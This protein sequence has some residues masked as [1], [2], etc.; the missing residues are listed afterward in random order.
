[1]ADAKSDASEQTDT[2]SADASDEISSDNATTDDVVTEDVRSQDPAPEDVEPYVEEPHVEDARSDV[3]EPAQEYDEHDERHASLSSRVLTW[4]VVLF[5]GAGIALWGGPKLAPQ[6]P[7]WAAPAAKFM[8]PGGDAAVRDVAA[9][10]SEVTQQLENVPQGPTPEELT[11]LVQAELSTVQTQ[12]DEKLA[13][14][15]A[16]IAAA[17]TSQMDARISTIETQV[18]GLTAE[19]NALTT[20]VQTALSE[21]GSVSEEALAEITSKSAEVE[22]VKAQ[23]GEITGQVGALT[24]RIED[25]EKAATERLEAA[26]AEAAQAQERAT[27]MAA[28]TAFLAAFD[29]LTAKASEG[30][31]YA[32]ELNTL[33]EMSETELPA[34]LAENATTGVASLATLKSQF[35]ARSHEAISWRRRSGHSHLRSGHLARQRPRAACGLDIFGRDPK[36]GA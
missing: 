29:E 30:S 5:A 9:L 2:L 15:E 36:V 28:N 24:Q 33:S 17:D 14:M 4:L 35:T 20:S 6:L 32:T 3:A 11:A 21:G 23:L 22:G 18:E 8:T 12:T 27:Q 7:E 31:P 1:M 34:V 26:K 19:L 13:S 25:A 16:Q 10:R